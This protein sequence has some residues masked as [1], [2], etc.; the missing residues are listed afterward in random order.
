MRVFWNKLG[1]KYLSAIEKGTLNVTYSDGM[2]K[3]YGNGQLPKADVHIHNSQVFKRM[4]LYGDIGFAESYM[5]GDFETSDL[6]ALITIGL[7]NSK[8]LATKSEDRAYNR[9][10]NL[11]PQLN[12]LKHWM[13]KNSKTQSQKNI[14]EHYDLSNNFFELMLDDTM[15]YSSAVFEHP[16]ESLY[17]AQQRKIK[18]LA[19]KLRLKPGAKVLEI[20]S[21]WGAMAIHLAKEKQCEVTTVTLSKEQK[22]LCEQRFK[23][24]EVEKQIEI[25]LKDYRDLE[26]T[27]DA[28][29]AVEMFEAVGKEYF[30]IF[31]KKCESLLKP[32]GV[33]VMQIITMPDQRY[34]AYS[35][36]TDFIQKYIFPGGHLPSVGKILETTS[37]HTR[38]NLLHMEEFTEDYAKTLRLWHEA[39]LQKLDEVK[40]LGFDEYFIRMWKMY[41]S[42]CEAAFITRNINLVQ[43]AFTRDQ[44]I[45]LNKGLVA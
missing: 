32:S 23:E 30:D 20:G 34:P 1:D 12:K 42:Y 17:S 4:S 6:T 44:N 15:M 2:Q 11:M 21:G 29:I 7:I 25:L 13:R 40:N 37:T 24:E 45:Q 39:F 43:V 28:I 36:G 19:D 9:F 22:A 14:S 33:M 5:D 18:L 3:T 41:L 35:K 16:E 27:F 26:G 38:L 31:F 8:T 10:I